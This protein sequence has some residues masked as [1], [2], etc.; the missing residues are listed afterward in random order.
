MTVAEAFVV[1]LG[2]VSVTEAIPFASV[3]P[4]EVFKVPFV[5]AN[6][7]VLPETGAPP[8]VRLADMT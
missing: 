7:I 2:A 1:L 5:V 8:L 4:V 6:V 3:T